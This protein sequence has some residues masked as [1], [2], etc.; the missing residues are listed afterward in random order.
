MATAREWQ[1]N[2]PGA[3]NLKFSI[4]IHGV[5][6]CIS[7]ED[8]QKSFTELSR[9]T[10]TPNLQFLHLFTTKHGLRFYRT[11][12]KTEE[13]WYS[14]IQL[15]AK[16]PQGHTIMVIST[17]QRSAVGASNPADPQQLEHVKSAYAAN[18]SYNSMFPQFAIPDP[19]TK[20]QQS[21]FYK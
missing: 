9:Q 20:P 16:I 2:R 3:L 17:S 8:L 11:T 21:I 4:T 12:Y 15:N 18:T 5:P 19:S 1:A 13:A 7:K 14:A 10:G 6:S